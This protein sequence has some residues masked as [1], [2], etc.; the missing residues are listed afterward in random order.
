MKIQKCSSEFRYI[1]GNTF[2]EPIYMK[3]VYSYD[4]TIDFHAL[5]PQLSSSVTQESDKCRFM[6]E[7]KQTIELEKY[8][9]YQFQPLMIHNLNSYNM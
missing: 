7:D 1:F 6:Q 2:V 5:A 4:K 8:L 3:V 9:D